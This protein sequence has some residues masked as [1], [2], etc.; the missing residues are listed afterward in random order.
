MNPMVLLDAFTELD[1]RFLLSAQ[2]R[3]NGGG[4][5]RTS[6][7]RVVLIAAV[8]AM[9]LSSFAAAMALN[10]EFREQVFSVLRIGQTERVPDG[11]GS[12][13]EGTLTPIGSGELDGMAKSYYFHGSGVIMLGDGMV[14][15]ARYDREA[16]SF[17]DFDEG[18][19]RPLDTRHADFHYTFRGTDYHIVYDCAVFN[20][21][22]YLRHMV[23]PIVNQNPILYDWDLLS[24]GVDTHTAWL[25][26]HY[27]DG[28]D[29]GVWPLQLDVQTHQITDVLAHVSADGV[30][31]EVWR[32][33]ADSSRAIVTGRTPDGADGCW[34]CDIPAGTLTP[35]SERIGRSVQSAYFVDESRIVCHAPNGAGFDVIRYDPDS[36]KK[37]VIVENTRRAADSADGS[38]WR[39]IQ[40]HGT[41][42][43]HA[44][45]CDADG[46]VTLLDLRDGARTALD[47]LPAD[48]SFLPFESPDGRYVL[49]A[50]KDAGDAKSDILRHIGVLDTESGVFKLLEREN[51]E[52]RTEH[53][54][55]WLANDC[56]TI[57]AYDDADA[58]GWYLYVYDFR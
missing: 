13:D 29:Y 12:V 45:M 58:G 19:L 35:L 48:G 6:N 44:L 21:A 46:R 42:G 8:L 1:D 41:P 34:L 14:Y 37:T 47:G 7:W 23:D 39:E 18:G 3:L 54:F 52:T 43:K 49:F 9:L 10:T 56:F 16:A 2:S 11:E 51:H 15:S 20:G 28:D 31:P 38:G 53:L 32:F 30:R 55:S 27:P 24:P 22:L 17:C 57:L 25:L 4:Q 5:R 50:W 36:G 33:S 26:L 40:Y